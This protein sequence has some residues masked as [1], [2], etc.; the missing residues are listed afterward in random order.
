[1]EPDRAL[2]REQQIAL[3]VGAQ[4]RLRGHMQRWAADPRHEEIVHRFDD[5]QQP[6]PELRLFGR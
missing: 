6:Q 4:A 3:M 1:M 2:T 5:S